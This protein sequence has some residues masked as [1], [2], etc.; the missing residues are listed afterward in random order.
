MTTVWIMIHLTLKEP[1]NYTI[2]YSRNSKI[3]EDAQSLLLL[4]SFHYQI[5]FLLIHD[6][7]EFFSM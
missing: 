2:P 4:K 3:Q 6:L 5:A 1:I 7:N